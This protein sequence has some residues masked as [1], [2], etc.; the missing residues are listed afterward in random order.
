MA[1]RSDRQLAQESCHVVAR[2]WL[3]SGDNFKR[4]GQQRVAGEHGDAVAEHFVAGGAPASKIV[5]IHAGKII[6]H[7]RVRVD[8][9]QRACERNYIADFSPA[10]FR[11]GQTENRPQPFAASEKTVAHR[12]VQG[13]GF[14]VRFRQVAIKSALNLSLVCSQ[15]A[16]EVHVTKAE[17]RSL[18]LDTGIL[19]LRAECPVSSA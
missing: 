3:R 5:I 6:V 12:P 14:A 19:Q 17:V 4:N 8:A 1:S 13:R 15:I 2:C 11:G 10:S 7:E 16:F 9:L 18:I